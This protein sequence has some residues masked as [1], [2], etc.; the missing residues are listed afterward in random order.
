MRTVTTL[1]V[2]AILLAACGVGTQASGQEPAAPVTG[3]PADG[4]LEIAPGQA[5][6]P[7]ISIEAAIAR[8]GPG[9]VLING[10]L[11]VRPDGVVLL[12]SALAE[13]LPPQCA[14]T[15]LEVRGLDLDSVPNLHQAQ[16]VRWADGVQLLGT[17]AATGT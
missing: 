1:A 5:V 3:D 16:G 6:G 13:S 4:I 14:G 8:G 2:T 10:A 12:C 9:P 17:V 15:R 7:G 11:V